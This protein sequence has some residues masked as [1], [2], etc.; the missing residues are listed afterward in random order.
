MANSVPGQVSAGPIDGLYRDD[1]G[2]GTLGLPDY[3]RVPY[4][5]APLLGPAD[6]SP[7][8][9]LDQWRN[10]A[11]AAFKGNPDGFG[12]L[13]SVG[14]PRGAAAIEVLPQAEGSPSASLDGNRDPD[15]TWGPRDFAFAVRHPGTAAWAA[16]NTRAYVVFRQ[17]NNTVGMRLTTSA[18]LGPWDAELADSAAVNLSGLINVWDGNAHTFA[19]A[20]LG[21][22]VFVLIDSVLVIPFRAPRAY[23]RKP[24]GTTDAT[25]FSNLPTTGDF[26]GYD[27][28]GPENYLYGW[29][30]LQPPSGDFFFYDM[31]ALTVQ[32]PPATT[33][34]PTTTPSGETWS[35]TGTVT[36]SKD[37]VLLAANAT[38]SFNVDWPYGVLSTRWGTATAEGGLVLRKV[39]ANNYYQVTST[40]IYHCQGG[41]LTKF[42]TFTTPLVSGNHVAV[43][44]FKDRIRVWVNG[45]SVAYYFASLHTTARGIGFR[46]PA[47][48]TSQW[49]YIAFQPLVSS[50]VLPTT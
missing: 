35:V 41:V 18:A 11:Y 28:R 46:S 27:A 14:G 25:V 42:H 23:K 12:A 24:D 20:T 50:I 22:N 37:G 1:P 30:A 44:N 49:R 47:A 19:V 8:W 39:D 13:R 26:V 7:Q 21:Q 17:D 15:Y 2:D 9:A 38:A 43:Q 40:G 16:A 34:T 5:Y 48:G 45:V 3:S 29:T 4:T 33:A 6:S 32:T 10:G 36:A 31:G